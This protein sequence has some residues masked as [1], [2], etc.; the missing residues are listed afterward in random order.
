VSAVEEAFAGMHDVL[1]DEFGE[2]ATVQRGADAPVAV[3][4]YIER[5]IEQLGEYGRVVARV[6][7][8]S[9]LNSEWTPAQGDV[10]VWGSNTRTVQSVDSDDGEVTKVVLHG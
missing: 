10:L 7:M 6:T 2:D 5:G 9:F 4:V 3:R 1:F 8:A